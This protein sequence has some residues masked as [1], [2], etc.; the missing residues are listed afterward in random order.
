MDHSSP[1]ERI[2]DKL[3]GYFAGV[4]QLPWS[5][6]YS[7]QY[8]HHQSI[9]VYSDTPS[10]IPIRRHLEAFVLECS[11]NT[12]VDRHQV[13]ET[14]WGCPSILF[15]QYMS[16]HFHVIYVKVCFTSDEIFMCVFPLYVVD[17]IIVACDV[18][19]YEYLSL[20]I[21]QIFGRLRYHGNY[22]GPF[23]HRWKYQYM[24]KH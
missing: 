18:L 13:N 1:W 9:E 15:K 3:D 4:S 17:S 7:C 11:P 12:L 22:F 10:R 5:Q 14:G 21:D 24:R 19:Y 20:C 16:V 8:L 23:Q 6:L 2:D